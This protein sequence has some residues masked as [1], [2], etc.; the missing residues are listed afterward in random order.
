M[1]DPEDTLTPDC[2]EDGHAWEYH[3]DSFDHPFGTEI[4]IY[5][6]CVRCGVREQGPFS[7]HDYD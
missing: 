7:E 1:T 5:R 6:R 4:D 2:D 3:D